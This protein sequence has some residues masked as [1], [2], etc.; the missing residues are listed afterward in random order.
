MAMGRGRSPGCSSF[1]CRT[2]I[3]T[4]R[5]PEDGY[6]TRES[7]VADNDVALGRIVEYLSTTPAWKRMAI[8]ITED[9]AQGGVDHVDSHRTI[10]LVGGPFAK[11]NYVSHTNAS[12]PSMLRT[13]FEILR[14]PPLNQFDA[15][16]PSLADC[17][18]D[19]ADYTA[20]QGT[21]GGSGD[22]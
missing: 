7:Y 15:S 8:F 9:D 17:F 16:A 12:F 22:L 1:T 10:L 4:G 6:P 11:K 2:T 3:W 13:A 19:A 21:A 14:L 18:T 20:V 5:A